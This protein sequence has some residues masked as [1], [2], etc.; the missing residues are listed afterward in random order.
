[1]V[2]G[3]TTPMIS[4]PF[5]LWLS[6]PFE[7]VVNLILRVKP[8]TATTCVPPLLCRH[9]NRHLNRHPHQRHP[10]LLPMI[11]LLNQRPNQ[12]P[13]QHPNRHR[14]RRLPSLLLMNQHHHRRLPSLLPMHR[15]LNRHPPR[16]LASLLLMNQHPH[17][18]L[19]SLPLA[20]RASLQS[21]P[22]P[23]QPSQVLPRPMRPR[24]LLILRNFATYLLHHQLGDQ[25]SHLRISPLM[26][27]M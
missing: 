23:P 2:M 3:V 12:H 11:R 14:P 9:P 13:N 4:I 20:N 10:S 8:V 5:L 18:R 24:I 1:M 16:R 21:L 19:P 6:I 22:A 15:H 17:R 25:P 26:P 7:T 27:S